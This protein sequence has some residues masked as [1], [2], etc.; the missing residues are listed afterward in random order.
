MARTPDLELHAL[1]RERIRRQVHSGLT[2]SSA[3]AN[4]SPWHRST[5][6]NAGCG[7]SISQTIDPHCPPHRP[8]S[9]SLCASSS[10]LTTNHCRSRQNCPMES[11]FGSRPRTNAWPPTW[12]ASL[13]EP[14]LTPEA[15]DD[16]PPS[17]RPGVPAHSGHRSP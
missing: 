14:G 7:S 10:T 11:A 6:G 4:V 5:L 8:F 17:T 2:R 16:Q 15:R 9:L 1:W 13:P 12:S 3:P